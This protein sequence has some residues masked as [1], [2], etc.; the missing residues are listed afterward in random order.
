VGFQLLD[1]LADRLGVR[2]RKPFLRPFAWARAEAGGASLVMVKPLTFMNRSGEVFPDVLDRTG[3]GVADLL[4]VCDTLDLPVGQ[5][6]LRRRGSSAGH[7]GLASIIG[8]L[9]REDFMR[10]YIGIGRPGDPG[11]VVD[12]V[13]GR[14]DPREAREIGEALRRA[15]GAVVRLLHEE[16]EKVMN[17]LNQKAPE[18]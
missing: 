8:R 12:Y 15:A 6:R 13:L 14:P 5:C 3:L 7:N 2:F 4:G 16:P 1:L 11:E 10:L 9:G 18:P 17:E